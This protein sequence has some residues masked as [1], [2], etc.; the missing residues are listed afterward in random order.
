MIDLEYERALLAKLLLEPSHMQ[1]CDLSPEEFSVESNQTIYQ[2][3]LSL[4][5]AKEPIDAVTVADKLYAETDQN[6]L[7]AV[8][9]LVQGVPA[10]SVPD[11]VDFVRSKNRGRKAQVIAQELLER[12]MA[13]DSVDNAIRDLMALA[14]PHQRHHYDL[15][16][17][18][19]DALDYVERVANGEMRGISSGFKDLD[20][21]LGGLHGGDL[22]IIGARP[23]MGKTAMLL[24]MTYN[25]L[26]AGE[27]IALFSGEQDYIQMAARLF[28]ISSD[29]SSVRMRNG[30]LTNEDWGRLGA[31]L[32]KLK[33]RPM[34]IDDMP[35]PSLD[36]IV[37][38][39]RKWK[40]TKNTSVILI[41]YLQRMATDP[42][43]KRFEGVGANVRGLKNLARELD[44]PII[45]LAQVSRDVEKRTDKRPSM[46]DLSDSSEVEKEADQVFMLYRDEVYNPDTDQQG[47]CEI[48]IDKN[49]HG[50]TGFVK[51]IW[52]GE[53]MQFKDMVR[54][55]HD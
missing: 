9:D 8:F 34:M 43:M 23:A 2:A 13:P 25:M 49:R 40:H 1:E 31:N 28:S 30:S 21:K 19:R 37:R 20:D 27:S 33:G 6:W 35:S 38:T 32:P 36:R 55:S 7:N 18:A 29:V 26:M 47:I 15:D 24:N 54:Y 12:A 39:A 41:D 4:N 44:V 50:P 45:A 5:A 48:L 22:I 3:L 14:Q 52:K 17:A 11:Y 53:T 16:E 10:T 46:G 51:T 42:K